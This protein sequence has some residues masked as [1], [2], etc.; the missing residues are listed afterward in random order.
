VAHVEPRHVLDD[1]RIPLG[2]VDAGHGVEA[3]ALVAGVDLQSET[4]VLYLM[5]P[6]V[7]DRRAL[8]AGR[9][10]GVDE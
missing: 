10:A 5:H 6:A 9:Q 7:R 1:P 2:P 3:H 4:V 8:G